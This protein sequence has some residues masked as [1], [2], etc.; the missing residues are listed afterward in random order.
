MMRKS[1]EE[2]A[3]EAANSNPERWDKIEQMVWTDANEKGLEGEEADEYVMKRTLDL[4]ENEAEDVWDI[5]YSRATPEGR[6]EQAKANMGPQEKKAQ[7]RVYDFKMTVFDKIKEQTADSLY[8]LKK[9]EK[10][11]KDLPAHLSG[12]KSFSMMSNFPSILGAFLHH[13]RVNFENNW[14]NV[15]PEKDGGLATVIDELGDTADDFFNRLTAKS[16]KEM[17]NKGRENLFGEGVDDSQQIEALMEGTEKTYHDN[18]Q[19]WD[20]AEDRL[21]ELNKSV[22][23]FAEKSGLVNSDQRKGWERSHYIPFYRVVEDEWSDTE[24]ETLFPKSGPEIG[25]IHKLEGSR[26]KVGDPMTNLIN[27]YSYLLNE[28]LKN[29]SRK[30]SLRLVKEVGLLEETT[31]DQRMKKGVV[32]IRIKG[33]SQYYKVKDAALYDAVMQMDTLTQGAFSKFLTLPK[34]LLTTGITFAPGFRMANLFRD[35]LHTWVL[36]KDFKAFLDS[37]RGFRHALLN[38]DIMKEFE[39]TGGAFRGA[40]H[41]RDIKADTARSVRRLKKGLKRGKRSLGNPLRWWEI[42][43]KIGEASENA[44]RLGLYMKKRKAGATKFEAAYEAKD[45]LDFHRTGKSRILSVMVH[46]IPF[47]NARI[48]GLYKIGRSATNAETRKTF[49]LRSALLGAAA[50]ALHAWNDDDDRYQDLPDYERMG[51]LHFFDIFEDNDHLRLPVPFEVGS[52][53]M[54]LPPAIW[55]TLKGQRTKSEL[56]KLA[57]NIAVDTFRIDMPQIMKPAVQQWANKDLY[58]GIPIV[59]QYEQK[60]DP[61]FQVG[62]GTTKTAQTIGKLTGISPK[63]VDQLN[64]DIFGTLGLSTAAATDWLISWTDAYP[65]DPAKKFGDKYYLWG[66]GRFY[67]ESGEVPRHIRAEQEFYELFNETD[68]AWTTWRMLMKQR[69]V[70]EA[71]LYKKKN[72]ERVKTGRRMS[73]MQKRIRM[74]NQKMKIILWSNKSPK[75]KRAEMDRLLQQRHAAFKR[76]MKKV[77]KDK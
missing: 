19:L 24:M 12:H 28:S 46:T 48:Q 13:G 68:G 4:F 14:I 64:K 57:W 50:L 25:K 74:L 45:I 5:R 77:K 60:L 61:E 43:N 29:L 26:K 39:S 76:A 8:A 20:W 41:Q 33:D 32:A 1:L 49:W 56:G 3:E 40:Y 58:T 55:E 51:Y 52:L 35:T 59:G 54:V 36:Q 53:F 10:P 42:W 17:Q 31:A 21:G 18:K 69:R 37:A 63:R 16:A 47:L 66:L 30:K 34:R 38:T 73:A 72:K 65:E 2:R 62:K 75:Q 67:K 7:D 70:R 11:F 71:R 44:A 9:L 27:A 6:Y 23:D 22:L 15:A